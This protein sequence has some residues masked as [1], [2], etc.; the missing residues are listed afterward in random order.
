MFLADLPDSDMLQGSSQDILAWVILA[1]I[2]LFI[3][4]CT[5]FIIRQNKLETKYD[6]L[7]KKT[8]K[9]ALRS[10]R[11]LEIVAN[12]PAPEIEEDLDDDDEEDD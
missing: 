8:M 11:A 9:I 6:R 7:Q 1:Q 3:A 2:A 12:L 10:Q 5:Y 4:V